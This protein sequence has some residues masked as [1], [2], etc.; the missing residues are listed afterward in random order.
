MRTFENVEELKQH[1]EANLRGLAKRALEMSHESRV[2]SEN[3]PNVR[4]K[5]IWHREAEAE[6]RIAK[7]INSECEQLLKLLSQD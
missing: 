6:K 7:I 2:R 1:I 3:E 4:L 5:E